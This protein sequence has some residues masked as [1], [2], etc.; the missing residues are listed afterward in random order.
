MWSLESMKLIKLNSILPRL[1]FG[2]PAPSPLQL[3]SPLAMNRAPLPVLE[4]SAAGTKTLPLARG[5]GSLVKRL[6][7]TSALRSSTYLT[8]TSIRHRA[9]LP[10]ILPLHF[11]PSAVPDDRGPL[12]AA[13]VL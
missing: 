7:S 9:D 3:L 6:T 2:L 8:G 13:L 12:L 1:P 11:S 4:P 5:H 10:P